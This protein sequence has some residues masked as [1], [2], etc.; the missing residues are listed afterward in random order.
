MDI[1]AQLYKEHSK[2][3]AVLIDQYIGNNTNRVRELINLILCEDSISHQRGAAVLSC[4]YDRNKNLILPFLDRLINEGLYKPLHVAVR[5][6]ILRCFQDTTPL[7]EE[8]LGL[9]VDHC[10]KTIQNI[11]ETVA[12]HAFS[13]TIIQ[14]SLT[15][16]P[17]LAQD[18]KPILEDRIPI[19][20][21]AFRYRAIKALTFINKN[22]LA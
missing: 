7:N 1:K 14:N 18:L 19:S 13:I 2:A 5:R 11:S 22:K 10:F 20:K 15:R 3:N 4:I 17:E 6:N 21:A 8:Q 12:L 9:V 16:Y